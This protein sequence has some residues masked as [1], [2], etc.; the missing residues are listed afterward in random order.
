M[1]KCK[2]V[3]GFTLIEVIST[4]V[5]IGILTV[6]AVSRITSTDEMNQKA[7]A[8]AIKSHI[9]YAQMRA[10]NAD[11]DT[12]AIATCASSFGISMSGNS[13]FMFRDCD[14]TKKVVF[15]GAED[16]FVSLNNMT[17]SAASDIT[18]DKWGRPCSD[19]YGLTPSAN[20]INLTLGTE[21]IKITK[22]TGYVP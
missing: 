14:K 21:P 2:R 9:R 6:I 17:L 19:L 16:D 13:Y 22:N 8:E 18:F 10:M 15:P 4:L 12:S 11:A 20:D 7:M 1:P 5:L 3:K